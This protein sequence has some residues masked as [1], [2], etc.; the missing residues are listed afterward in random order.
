MQNLRNFLDRL[1]DDESGATLKPEN[2]GSILISA[3]VMACFAI[4]T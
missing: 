4:V 2:P 3:A 1:A